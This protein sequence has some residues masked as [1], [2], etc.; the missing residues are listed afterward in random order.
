LTL[1]LTPSLE[2]RGLGGRGHTRIKIKLL[3]PP[4]KLLEITRML[5]GTEK[6]SIVKEHARQLLEKGGV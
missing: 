2:G 4:E 5:G 6:D 3:D 1:P